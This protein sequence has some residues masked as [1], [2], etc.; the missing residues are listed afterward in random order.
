MFEGTQGKKFIFL[1]DKKNTSFPRGVKIHG[2]DDNG[3]ECTTEEKT[4][5]I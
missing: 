4:G 3:K 1:K 5:Q 2:M